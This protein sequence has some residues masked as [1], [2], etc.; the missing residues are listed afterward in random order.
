MFYYLHYYFY[1]TILFS[2]F[3]K[4]YQKIVDFQDLANAWLRGLFWRP[5]LG[6]R[7]SRFLA[8]DSILLII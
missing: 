8:S 3:I 1:I 7:K 4:S 2:Y 6:A 5:Q